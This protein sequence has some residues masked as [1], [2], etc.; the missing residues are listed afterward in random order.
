MEGPLGD[1]LQ[2]LCPSSQVLF[3]LHYYQLTDNSTWL[4]AGSNYQFSWNFPLHNTPVTQASTFGRGK[5]GLKSLG[6][7]FNV[8]GEAWSTAAKLIQVSKS[9]VI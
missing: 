4:K 2:V 6:E 7:I 3:P 5:Q 9:Q 1:A 8:A